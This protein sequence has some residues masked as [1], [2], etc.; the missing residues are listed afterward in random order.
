MFVLYSTELT[1]TGNMATFQSLHHVTKIIF[2]WVYM[3]QKMKLYSFIYFML[4]HLNLNLSH[5][6]YI[7][8][9]LI[10]H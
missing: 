8:K 6:L 1:V 10:Q 2:K 9:I 7:F 4:F 5:K 3:E